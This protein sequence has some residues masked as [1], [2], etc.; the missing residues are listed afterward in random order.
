[1]LLCLLIGQ[2]SLG[3]G[4]LTDLERFD[5]LPFLNKVVFTGIPYPTIRSAFYL[6][7]LGEPKRANKQVYAT[8]NFITGKRYIDQFDY[9]DFFNKVSR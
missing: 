6:K 4:N 9:I 7:G 8:Q 3:G 5:A 2:E 1:M